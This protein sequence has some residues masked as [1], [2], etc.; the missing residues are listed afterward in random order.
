MKS[1]LFCL[2][3]VALGAGATVL[4]VMTLVIPKFNKSI[5]E[6]NRVMTQQSNSIHEANDYVRELQVRLRQCH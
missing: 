5:D 2:L 6:D 4:I 3:G 1:A